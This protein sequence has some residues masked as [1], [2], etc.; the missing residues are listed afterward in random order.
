MLFFCT[1]LPITTA[2]INQSTDESPETEPIGGYFIFGLMHLM[3]PEESITDFEIVS[4]VYLVGN[5]NIVR[6]N[7]GEL[8]EIHEPIFAIVFN[9]LFVGYIGDY[10]MIG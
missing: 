5:G 9:N 3:N 8:I 10:S 2:E 6:L 7:E 4:F 1:I